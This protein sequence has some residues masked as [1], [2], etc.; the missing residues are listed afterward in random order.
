MQCDKYSGAVQKNVRIQ[1]CN[2]RC[3]YGYEYHSSNDVSI[4]C[5]GSCIQIACVVEDT[6]KDIGE[7]W[8]SYDHCVT[9][10][11]ESKNGTVRNINMISSID[12]LIKLYNC[13]I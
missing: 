4:N 1:E 6:L 10:V 11:C 13:L 7:K 2:T 12:K 5:C 3:D 8:Y 9:Y